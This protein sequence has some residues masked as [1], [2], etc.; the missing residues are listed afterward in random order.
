MRFIRLLPVGLAVLCFG[1]WLWL[2]RAVPS[3]AAGADGPGPAHGT[4]KKAQTADEHIAQAMK[5]AQAQ[6]LDQATDELEAA[7]KVDPKHRQ[8]LL[9]MAAV[10]YVRAQQLDPKDAKARAPLTLRAAEAMRTLRSTYKDLLPQEQNLLGEILYQEAVARASE[11]QPGPALDSLKEAV[12]AGFNDLDKLQDDEQLAS[13]RKLPEFA[14]MKAELEAKARARAREHAQE[15]LAA[16]KPFPFSFTLT[17]LEGKKARLADLKGRVTIVDVWGTWCPPC[18]KEI[19]HFVELYKKYQ[20]RGL[21]IVGINY[22]NE[23]EAEARKTIREFVQANGIP[24]PCVLGDEATQKQI[25]DFEGFP[26]TLF[27][28]AD[29]TVRLK[30]VGYHPLFDLEAIITALLE[31]S[32]RAADAKK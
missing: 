15:L 23:E 16:N 8:A 9:L 21:A 29:G 12:E 28:D 3:P 24:Y 5:A 14:K 6:H 32:P 25:P 4:Q 22:E 26:T 11:G 30:V 20:D 2:A 10:N 27:L 31:E 13:I 17:D 1:G 18:R 7:L 19:P